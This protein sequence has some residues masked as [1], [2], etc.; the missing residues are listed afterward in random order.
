M[1]ELL[2]SLYFMKSLFKFQSLYFFKIIFNNQYFQFDLKIL[3][4]N[5]FRMLDHNFKNKDNESIAFFYV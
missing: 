4:Q 1:L 2:F 3:V 5:N